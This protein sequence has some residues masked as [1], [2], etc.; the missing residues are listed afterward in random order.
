MTKTLYIIRGASGSGKTTLAKKLSHLYNV[1]ADDFMVNAN[2]EYYFDPKSL[3]FV[4]KK[5]ELAVRRFMRSKA[6]TIAV[7]NT[8]TQ[9]WEWAVYVELAKE[10]GYTV[11]FIECQNDF[12][13]EHGCPAKTVQHQRD[14]ME[15]PDYSAKYTVGA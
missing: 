9:Q 14:K 2:G 6:P 1:A 12:G 11:F 10:Y 5:C 15:R 3:P 8:F 4:H 13:N 7:H